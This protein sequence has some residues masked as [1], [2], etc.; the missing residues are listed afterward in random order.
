MDAYEELLALARGTARTLLAQ[1][2]APRSF[3]DDEGAV[4]D[5]WV[6]DRL[7]AWDRGGA[8]LQT[9]RTEVR[10]SCALVLDVNGR[11][12]RYRDSSLRIP[13]AGGRTV[14]TRRLELSP[15]SARTL[16]ALGPGR[17]FDQVTAL[18]EQLPWTAVPRRPAARPQPV[19]APPPPP[20][21][22]PSWAR[23]PDPVPAAAPAAD[24]GRPATVTGALVGFAGGCICAA[25]A[26]LACTALLG[27]A[28]LAV[29]LTAAA[30]CVT[31]G[32]ALGA[33]RGGPGAG[34][35]CRV[36]RRGVR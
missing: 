25:A 21:A 24:P 10:S 11:F 3:R 28:A 34:S 27:N 36:E 32:T 4:V 2:V 19:A 31:T 22:L 8:A 14:V 33:V 18:L 23:R 15:A 13:G 7:P 9:R 35:D 30:L 1:G 29:G 20:P 12:H 6:V 5:G 16:V 17:P 26:S